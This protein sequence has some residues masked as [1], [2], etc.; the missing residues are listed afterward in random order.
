[1][2]GHLRKC[3]EQWGLP[4]AIRV[5]NGDP[6]ATR[7]DI[8]AALALWLIG[9]NVK[10][11]L[12]RP[13]QSTDNG[14]VERDHGVLAGWVEAHKAGSVAELQTHIDWAMEMQRQRYPAMAGQS[15]LQAYPALLENPRRYHEREEKDLWL[16]ERVDEFLSHFV[17]IR[18]VDK[19]GRISLFSSAYSVGR[20]YAGRDITVRLDR[21]NRHW[22]ME[23]EQGERLKSYPVQE[24]VPERIDNLDLAKRA[25]HVSHLTV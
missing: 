17:W 19:V 13:S 16:L 25:N 14:I 9:L 5:D 10:V 2:R 21:Q 24:I 6:W 1:M 11:I 22:I 15:R 20:A 3:F 18:R 8:P 4:K 7:S 12:N 23:T